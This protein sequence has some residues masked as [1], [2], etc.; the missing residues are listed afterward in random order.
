MPVF[1]SEAQKISPRE[2]LS[3]KGEW[4][5]LLGIALLLI[6]T[7]FLNTAVFAATEPVLVITFVLGIV[8]IVAGAT[9]RKSKLGHF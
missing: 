4:A 6:A 7:F 1:E 9:Y 2:K 8:L 3:R 5:I